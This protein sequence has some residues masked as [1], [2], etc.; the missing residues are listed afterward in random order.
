MPYRLNAQFGHIV[1]LK[2]TLHFFETGPRPEEPSDQ[3]ALQKQSVRPGQIVHTIAL[4]I[5][6]KTYETDT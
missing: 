5:T 6:L 3:P 1:F 2:N 4:N